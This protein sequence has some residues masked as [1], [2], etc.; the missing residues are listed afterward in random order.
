MKSKIVNQR[1]Q[2][3]PAINYAVTQSWEEVSLQVEKRILICEHQKRRALVTDLNLGFLLES[4]SQIYQR[5]KILKH[6]TG[7]FDKRITNN[8]RISVHHA[9][10]LRALAKTFQ[11]YPRLA[12]L[13][14]TT[15]EVCNRLSD[16]LKVLEIPEY[17][18]F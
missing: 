15:T 14:L 4:G 13:G 6:V 18:N 17:K 11:P 1:P 5:E 9:R 8:A 7:T 2:E 3:R 12:R 10:R 16:I